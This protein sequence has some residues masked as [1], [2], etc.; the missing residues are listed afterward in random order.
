MTIEKFETYPMFVNVNKLKCYIYM[1]SKK[2]KTI[3]VNI[4]G[5]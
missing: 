2:E 3:D 4:L 1:E 5:T